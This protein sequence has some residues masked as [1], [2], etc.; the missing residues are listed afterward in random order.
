MLAISAF[1]HADSTT[2]PNPELTEQ[3]STISVIGWFFNNDSVTYRI[4]QSEWRI[5]GTD[6]TRVA[7]V[8]ITSQFVVTD[9]TAD[10]Y[11]IKYTIL[12]ITGDSVLESPIANFQNKITLKLSKKLIGST[13]SFET[14]EYGKITKFNNLNQLKRQAKSMFKTAMDELQQMPEVQVL[15]KRN[16]DISKML[17]NIDSDR[18]VDDYLKEIKMLFQC[19]GTVYTIGEFEEQTDA[20]DGQ[21]EYTDWRNIYPDPND[22]SYHIQFSRTYI[23]PPDAFESIA[24][25]LVRTLKNNAAKELY[26]NSPVLLDGTHTEYTQLD[27]LSSGWPYF[28]AHQRIIAVSDV[29]KIRQTTIS[30]ISYK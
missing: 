4:M 10:S 14:N 3:D 21:F 12:D 2:T 19:H 26:L 27:F 24:G 7:G 1:T 29:K 9:S 8:I 5:N 20:A 25:D 28:A 11:K 30:M 23:L 13:V 15:K 22:N 18:L 17:G 6:T 16:V